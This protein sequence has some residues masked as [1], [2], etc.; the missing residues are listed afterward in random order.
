MMWNH[1]RRIW[2]FS[3]RRRCKREARENMF[4]KILC[5]LAGCCAEK[6]KAIKESVP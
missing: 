2:L 4:Q 5:W 1:P 3:S 6:D